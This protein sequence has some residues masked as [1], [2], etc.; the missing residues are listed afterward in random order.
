MPCDFTGLSSG[1]FERLVQA[2]AVKIIGPHVSIFGAGPDG[3]REATFDGE[4]KV[5]S[6]RGPAHT[7]NGY[8]VLQA[9]FRQRPIDS[10]KDGEWAIEQLRQELE[11]YADPAKGRRKPDYYVFATN[12]VLTPVK[13]KGSKDRLAA[14]FAKFKRRVPIRDFAIWDYDQLT[15]FLETQEDIRHAYAAWITPGDVLSEVFKSLRGVRP[16]FAET[17]ANFLAK[18][19]CTDQYARLEQAGHTA[20]EKIPL[21]PVFVDLA[22]SNE[23]LSE[24]PEKADAR[25]QKE[26]FVAQMLAVAQDRLDAAGREPPA[27]PQ[28]ATEPAPQPTQPGR[29]VLIGGPGQGKTTIGQFLCQLFRAA[30]LRERTLP[31]EVREPLRAIES[32]CPAE[33]LQLPAARRFPLRVVLNEFA[34]ALSRANADHK[35]TLLSYLV[36]HI[37]KRTDREVSADVFREWLRKYPWV[38]ILDGLD[39]VPASSNRADVLE[40]IKGFWI[41]AAQCSADVLVIATTRPQGYSDDFSSRHYQHLWLTP[42]SPTR[43]IHYA[44]RLAEVKITDPSKRETVLTDLRNAAH[45]EA[46][47]RLMRSPLQVTIMHTLVEHGG[48]PPQDRWKLFHDYY[49]TIYRREKQRPIPA[50][51]L[52]QTRQDDIDVIHGRVA[53]V[54][55]VQNERAGGTEAKLTAGQFGRIVEDRLTEEGFEG[56]E[57][58]EMRTGL[59]DAAAHRLVFLTGLEEGRVGFEIPSLREFMAAE[60]LFEK[61]ESVIQQRLREIAPTSSWRNVFLFAAGRCFAKPDQQHLRDTIVTICNELNETLAGPAGAKVRA[62]ALL[63]MDL[64]EDGLDRRSPKYAK[65]LARTALTLLD[66]PPNPAHKRLADL[67]RENLAIVFTEEISHRMAHGPRAD[68]LGPW[69][70]IGGGLGQRA[71]WAIELAQRCWPT[72]PE[73][74]LAIIGACQPLLPGTW[75]AA[76]FFEMA[77]HAEPRRWL[78]HADRAGAEFMR[79]SRPEDMQRVPAWLRPALPGFYGFEETTPVGVFPASGPPSG[80][81]SLELG[82]IPLRSIRWRDFVQAHDVPGLHAGWSPFIH[83]GSFA[84]AP[85]PQ[86]L[87][88]ALRAIA[89]PYGAALT[90]RLPWANLPWPLSACI[91][92]AHTPSAFEALAQH[93]EAGDLGDIGDW[94]AAEARWQSHGI[95]ADDITYMS[96]ARWPFDRNIGRVGFPFAADCS[97]QFPAASRIPSLLAEFLRLSRQL[98]PSR[99]SSWLGS[100]ILDTLSLSNAPAEWLPMP[101][102]APA[103][104]TLL[105]SP[106]VHWLSAEFVEAVLSQLSPREDWRATA[107]QI[108]RHPELYLRNGFSPATLRDIVD[109]VAEDPTLHGILCLIALHLRQG[110]RVSVDALRVDPRSVR[111]PYL[112]SAAIIVRLSQSTLTAPEAED[113]ADLTL[114]MRR[115]DPSAI[116]VVLG[117]IRAQQ[118]CAPPIDA[119]LLRLLQS[120]PADAVSQRAAVVERLTDSLRRRQSDLSDPQHWKELQFRPDLGDVTKAV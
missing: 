118:S 59:M 88:S 103:F 100:F 49:E 73:D 45:H 68:R 43:A 114:E 31:P 110:T 90:S 87:A 83:A 7:W 52:L 61:Q 36:T 56:S 53:L 19:L 2:L 14:E 38:L 75:L 33:K 80:Q 46:T 77:P 5:P 26:D 63:A 94:E 11:A 6:S 74:Q 91:K 58:E 48:A 76:K 9:K 116:R 13:K 35:P 21:A 39:E 12:V 96:D 115:D 112:R 109:A 64:L 72:D 40:A 113:L 120:L 24:P 71:R 47:A 16:D 66:L 102:S 1:S 51:K 55:Q 81:P 42:L 54:L 82:L 22:V 98:A 25:I 17:M 32:A 78:F 44:E 62:G 97:W 89:S 106:S 57:R 28:D 27:P 3:G 84:A 41:D 85:S 37:C 119:Y 30:L 8:G 50:A 105:G 4:T 18:E 67:H 65:L 111:E 95:A 20:D 108:G 93:A 29:F 92:S 15:A 60:A 10:K 107:D 69:A 34:A 70:T 86:L 99:M 79:P 104:L 117:A 101:L 23:R